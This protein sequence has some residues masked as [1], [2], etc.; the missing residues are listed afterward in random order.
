MKKKLF[1]MFLAATI[2][3]SSF[4]ISYAN[5]AIKPKLSIDTLTTVAEYSKELKVSEFAKLFVLTNTYN[6][7]EDAVDVLLQKKYILTEDNLKQSEPIKINEAV[8]ILTRALNSNKKLTNEQETELIKGISKDKIKENKVLLVEDARN[9]IINYSN[10]KNKYFYYQDLEK[11][12]IGDF[13]KMPDSLAYSLTKDGKTLVYLKTWEKRLNIFTKDV[14][15]G[16]E[17]QITKIKDRDMVAYFVKDNSIIYLKDFG[18]DENY[19]IF[20]ADD[21]GNEVDLTP[22]EGARAVPFDMLEDGAVKDEIL[23]QMNKDNK[24]VFSVYKLNIRTGE[25][26]KVIDN[27]AGYTGFITDNF[28]K[29]RVATFTDGVNSGYLYRETEEDEFK[30][31]K[32]YDFHESAN[33]IMF[34]EDNKTGYALSNIGRNTT[35]LVKFD[36]PTG[37]E[38]EVVYQNDKV[39]I[40]NISQGM[41]KGT[42]GTVSYTTDKTKIVFFDKYYEK[43]YNAAKLALNTDEDI[44]LSKLYDDS[45]SVI[46]STYSDIN[47]GISYLFDINKNTLV[48]LTDINI[49]DSKKMAEMIPISYKSRDGLTIHGYLT[50][51]KNKEAKNLPVI[52]NPHGGPWARDYWRFNPEVQLFA[53]RGYAVLQMNFRGST[54]YGTEFL[55]ASYKQWGQNMQNDITDGVQWLVDIGIANPDKIG[56]YGASYGGYATLAGVTF[57][58]DLYAAAVDYVG[59]SNLTTFLDT[60]PPY[61]ESM[62]DMMYEM[63]GNPETDKEMLDKYSPSLHADKIK[64]PLFIAQGANDP[65]VKKSESDQMVAALQKNGIEVQYMVKDDEGHGFAKFENQVDFYTAMIDFFEKHLK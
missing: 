42:I 26:S 59:V 5:D 18:G 41:K 13:F 40:T 11:F 45:K 21:N 7:G 47:R 34:G 37:T 17:K 62:R 19:H 48:K 60:M 24:Q 30:L 22:F 43:I 25:L 64:T 55:E 27:T 38:L 35:A 53:N 15:S 28:G 29:V 6:H 39:D 65:R 16:E 46:I 36:I 57:T 23:I 14:Q 2:S 63:V 8:K 58:P 51:P 9:L 61:W 12:D 52:I 49:L 20:K 1:A 3:I 10:I 31:V 44:S 50:L 54:G 4:S 32:T 33:V 56:I